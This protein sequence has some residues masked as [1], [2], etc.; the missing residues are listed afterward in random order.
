MAS[1]A[2][3][4][5]MY[6]LALFEVFW[7]NSGPDRPHLL[8][9]PSQQP[10]TVHSSSAGLSFGASHCWDSGYLGSASELRNAGMET[11]IS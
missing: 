11:L 1:K 4:E 3:D 9:L 7:L 2:G 6:W 8:S 10:G 5:K